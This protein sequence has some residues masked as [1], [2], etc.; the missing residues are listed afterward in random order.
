MFFVRGSGCALLFP[1]CAL[2]KNK[3]VKEAREM[4]RCVIIVFVVIMV[5]ALCACGGNGKKDKLTQVISSNPTYYE[6]VKMLG[7]PN[8][9]EISPD[10]TIILYNNYVFYGL[11]G[12]LSVSFNHSGSEEKRANDDMSRLLLNCYGEAQEIEKTVSS[13]I[14]D[15]DKFFGEHVVDSN[16]SICWRNEQRL[17]IYFHYYIEAGALIIAC[18]W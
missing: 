15:Y 7:E 13:I 9:E 2:Q 12:E 11:S 17:K 5:I 16:G 14:T 4:R 1:K 10:R 3:R 18:E 8:K 6:T